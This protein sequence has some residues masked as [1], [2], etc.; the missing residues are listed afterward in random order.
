MRLDQAVPSGDLVDSFL[1]K[2]KLIL[3]YCY[4]YPA[5]LSCSRLDPGFLHQRRS[6]GNGGTSRQ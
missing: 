5:S 6:Q 4:I 1:E 3:S 2:S